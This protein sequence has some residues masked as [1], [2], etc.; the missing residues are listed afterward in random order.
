MELSENHIRGTL[1]TFGIKLGTATTAAFAEKVN[2]MV[3]DQDTLVQATMQSL[4]QAREGL[5]EQEKALD[6]QCKA[7][8]KGDATCRRLMT[9]PGVGPI[10][11]LAYKAEVDDPS[12]AIPAHNL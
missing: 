10:T 3:A 7:L 4:L 11:A 2:E 1:K 12:P 5:L 9:V 6:G 8:A